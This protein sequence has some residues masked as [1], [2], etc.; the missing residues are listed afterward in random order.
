[1]VSKRPAFS[2]V[3]FLSTSK[4]FKR[5]PTGLEPAT[6]FTATIRCEPFRCVSCDD[7]TVSFLHV[8]QLVHLLAGARV[9]VPVDPVELV[10]YI[11]VLR[12]RLDGAHDAAPVLVLP[13]EADSPGGD[14]V[15]C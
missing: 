9:K 7:P 11:P 14:Q 12:V 3:C 15:E 1:V 4:R 6:F 13:D 10:V 2:R 8:G 5:Q